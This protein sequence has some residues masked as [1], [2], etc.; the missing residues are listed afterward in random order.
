MS[1]FQ[2]V[3]MTPFYNPKKGESRPKTF[4]RD[5]SSY[6]EKCKDTSTVWCELVTDIKQQTKPYFD[7]DGRVEIKDEKYEDTKVLAD[8][9]AKKQHSKSLEVL[10]KL[11]PNKEISVAKRPIR[12]EYTIKTETSDGVQTR[13]KIPYYKISY[14]YYVQ[15]CRISPYNIKNLLKRNNIE[16]FDTSVYDKNRIMILPFFKKPVNENDPNP[17]VLTPEYDGDIFEHESDLFNYCASYIEESYEDLDKNVSFT[18]QEVKDTDIDV[19]STDVG[20]YLEKVCKDIDKKRLDNFEDW[21]DIMFAIINICKKK[22]IKSKDTREFCHKISAFSPRYEDERVDKWFSDSYDKTREKGY[23]YSYLINLIKEDNPELWKEQYNKPSY[24]TVKDEFEK[25]CFKCVNNNLYI[26]VNDKRDEIDKE[27]FFIL[28]KKELSD[29]YYHLCY[30]ERK[31]D[32]KGNWTTIK[33]QFIFEWLKDDKIK[34]FQSVYFNPKVVESPIHYNLFKGFRAQLLPVAKNYEVIKPFLNHIK[35]VIANGDEKIYNYLIQYFANLIQHPD[36]KTNTIIIIQGMQ[37][38]GK[39]VVTDTIS[40]KI[41]GQ[42]YAVSS[43]NPESL[44]FGNFNSL[45]TN[46]V[47][48]VINEAG[49]ELRTC[50]DKIKDNSVTPTIPIV[51]KGH[52]PLIFTNYA[53]YVGTTNNLNPLDIAFDDRRFCWLKSSSKY[54][55][56]EAYFNQLFESIEHHDFESS[57]YHYLLEEVEITIKNFQIERPITKEYNQIRVRNLPNVIKFFLQ[58]NITFKKCR[59]KDE[60]IRFIPANELYKKYKE[61][62]DDN[63]FSPTNSDAFK[64]YIQNGATGIIYCRSN[65]ITGYRIEEQ[66]FRQW[67]DKFNIVDIPEIDDEMEDIEYIESDVE[68]DDNVQP[69]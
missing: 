30:Y 16:H 23:G 14:R 57:L 24:K 51:K 17:T 67:L 15:G 10:Y 6:Q 64:G 35:E 59:G 53:N 4:I 26:D 44:F 3:I 27:V 49:N 60:K 46:K 48:C 41:I 52:D 50:M 40:E 11:F 54:I 25:H 33:K 13:T 66:Q 45:L 1:D 31:C 43:S 38:S 29:K 32:K 68:D 63:K 9:I 56:N 36:K 18:K 2:S 39:S 37:G 69:N 61:Y 19:E 22:G 5:V 55:G 42:D 20:K 58:Y 62:C 65:H 8:F 21:R 7:F 28:K 12:I 47:L 34:M